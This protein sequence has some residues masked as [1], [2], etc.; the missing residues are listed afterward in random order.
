MSFTKIAGKIIDKDSIHAH[1]A[2]NGQKMLSCMLYLK[3]NVK[4]AGELIVNQK[5]ENAS[6]V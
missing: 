1:Y 3:K 6:V 2:A 5:D 4:R